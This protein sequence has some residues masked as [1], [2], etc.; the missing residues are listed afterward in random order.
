ML[1]LLGCLWAATPDENWQQAATAAAAG[2]TVAAAG[3][4]RAVIEAGM[5]DADAYYNLGNMLFRQNKYAGAILAWRRALVLNPRDPDAEANLVFARRKIKDQMEISQDIP[6]FAPWQG[7]MS[8]SEGQWGG[9]LLLGLGLLA[10]GLRQRLPGAV[11]V[12]ALIGVAL[13]GLMGGGGLYA[14][15]SAQGA[16]ILSEEVQ[17]HSDLSGGVVLFTLHAGAEV[18]CAE[19]AAGHLLIALSD[20]RKGWVETEAVGIVDPFAPLPVL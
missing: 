7:F 2:D 16:V 5:I 15:H 4:Y 14:Q 8:A 9:G 17:V 1:A 10:L 20:G 3:A 19:N 6:W 11:E 18:S 12:P 13:G